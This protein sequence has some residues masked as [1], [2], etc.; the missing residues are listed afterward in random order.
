MLIRHISLIVTLPVYS[1]PILTAHSCL[2]VYHHALIYS[3]HGV[4]VA[5]TFLPA[6]RFCG[7][8]MVDLT[9]MW[10]LWD[11]ARRL[12]LADS[13]F[14][15][16]FH[17]LYLS[18]TYGFTEAVTYS[19]PPMFQRCSYRNVGAFTSAPLAAFAG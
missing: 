18:A 8:L 19:E 13:F 11:W 9:K 3:A 2:N 17:C 15:N 12:D 7:K 16:W 6:V 4:V 1:S 14:C 5:C 10:S